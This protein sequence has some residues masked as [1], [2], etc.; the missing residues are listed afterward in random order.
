M[1][2]TCVNKV[3]HVFQSENALQD[4][5]RELWDIIQEGMCVSSLH[6]NV[7]TLHNNYMNIHSFILRTDQMLKKLLFSSVIAWKSF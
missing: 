7:L 4:S 2:Q 3:Q 5:I 1:P 6:L